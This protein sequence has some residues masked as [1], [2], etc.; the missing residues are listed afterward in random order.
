MWPF[1]V[2][3]RE[4][5]EEP[6]GTAALLARARERGFA[7]S[8]VDLAA[9]RAARLAERDRRQAQREQ[10]QIGR[11]LERRGV[12]PVTPEEPTPAGWQRV[13]GKVIAFDTIFNT[14][15]AN[16][17][18]NIMQRRPSIAAFGPLALPWLM[19]RE[20]KYGNPLERAKESWRGQLPAIGEQVMIEEFGVPEGLWSALGGVVFDTATAPTT[21]LTLGKGGVA[22]AAGRAAVGG[23][24]KGAIST[25]RLADAGYDV[26]R[27]GRYAADDAAAKT[28]LE[29]GEITAREMSP[30]FAKDVAQAVSREGGKAAVG[31]AREVGIPLLR[32]GADGGIGIG[33]IRPGVEKMSDDAVA[34]FRH[35]GEQGVDQTLLTRLRARTGLSPTIKTWG[36]VGDNVMIPLG[37]RGVD[38]GGIKF[39]GRTILDIQPQMDVAGQA[40][41]D[42]L[43]KTKAGQTVE[44]AFNPTAVIAQMGNPII[45]QYTKMQMRHFLAGKNIGAREAFVTGR[46]LSGLM[47][48][49]E[50]N[51]VFFSVNEMMAPADRAQRQM[52]RTAVNEKEA[53]LVRNMRY[54]GVS[55]EDL[56]AAARGERTEAMAE[57]TGQH[58]GRA[59]LIGE[60]IEELDEI[61]ARTTAEVMGPLI[62]R[63]DELVTRAGALRTEQKS[64]LTT[65]RTRGAAQGPELFVERGA[66]QRLGTVNTE[67]NQVRSDLGKVMEQINKSDAHPRVRGLLQNRLLA[68]E[69]FAVAVKEGESFDKAVDRLLTQR[70]ELERLYGDLAEIN[71]RVS[72]DN[73][74]AG[75]VARGVAPER[76]T[77][78]VEAVTAHNT[79][80]D[81]LEAWA[82]T[83]GVQ[84]AELYEGQGA[85][86]YAYQMEQIRPSLGQAMLGRL[87]DV[88]VRA[89]QAIGREPVRGLFAD[90]RLAAQRRVIDEEG[91]R[92]GEFYHGQA[93]DEA[94]AA[95]LA[96]AA[97]AADDM[98][99]REQARRLA[100]DG[101]EPTL[102]DDAAVLADDTPLVEDVPLAPEPIQALPRPE[103][104]TFKRP[105]G[106]ET[107]DPWDDVEE[108]TARRKQDLSLAKRHGFLVDDKRSKW[109]RGMAEDERNINLEQLARQAPT[110]IP[111]VIDDL[112]TILRG[113]G[114]K[115]QHRGINA[116][117]WG[118]TR[119]ID[120]LEPFRAIG[121][122]TFTD[123][124]KG[125][126]VEEA[127]RRLTERFPGKY[128][129][130]TEIGGLDR[131]G[132]MLQ[133]A[134]ALKAARLSKRE[135]ARLVREVNAAD[136]T[137]DIW[138]RTFND[139]QGVFDDALD[140]INQ[141]MRIGDTDEVRHWTTI[142]DDMDDWLKAN[143]RNIEAYH[144]A[145]GN[146]SPFQWLDDIEEAADV[147]AVQARRFPSTAAV[148]DEAVPTPVAE[149]IRPDATDFA[150]EVADDG[151][152][153]AIPLQQVPEGPTP[154]WQYDDL[155]RPS[156]RHVDEGGFRTASRPR[157]AKERVFP[158]AWDRLRAGV[159]TETDYRFA[160]AQKVQEIFDN[161]AKAD[162]EKNIL[163]AFG[164]KAAS[165][166][167]V[168]PGEKI[169]VV[170]RVDETGR[171]VIKE[172]WAIPE[173]AHGW[174]DGLSRAFANDES[175]NA[176][177]RNY[178]RFLNFW[179][180]QATIW[181][182]RFH[183]RNVASNYY[184]AWAEG[185]GSPKGWR[186]A[187]ELLAYQHAKRAGLPWNGPTEMLIAGQRMSYDEILEQSWKTGAQK[188]FHGP[189]EQV[190]QQVGRDIDTAR[191]I[192]RFGPTHVGTMAGTFVEDGSRLSVF[193][194]AMDKGLEPVAA[195][196]MVDRALFN[197]AAAGQTA[198]ERDAMKRAFPFY[199]WTR[200]VIPK[201]LRI[202]ATDPKRVMWFPRTMANF[203]AAADVDPALV[204]DYAREMGFLPLPGIGTESGFM[205]DA[206][207]RVQLFNPSPITI[208]DLELIAPDFSQGVLTGGQGMIRNILQRATPIASLPYE[209]A[210]SKQLFGDRTLTAQRRAP[211]P[212]QALEERFAGNET[213]EGIKTDLGMSTS[214]NPDTGEEFVVADARALHILNTAS[215]WLST[216][217]SVADT[218]E[219]GARGRAAFMGVRAISYE[220]EIA[221]Q[222]QEEELL[223]AL[224]QQLREVREAEVMERR[225]Q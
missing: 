196:N 155:V 181:N 153:G 219:R 125:I 218:G 9:D 184:M 127:V 37:T 100:D 179:K 178:D 203:Q 154:A 138:L 107:L 180:R 128:D 106:Y 92:A 103:V 50:A 5:E 32:R 90:R 57:L 167:D 150:D 222:R 165:I 131:L 86:G 67:L 163:P 211:G 160:S 1:R 137:E 101:Y 168:L 121:I 42:A 24:G 175:A 44:R 3:Q 198:F 149:P 207:G 49:E 156:D 142:A 190:G 215:P 217:M 27:I 188:G 109:M 136:Y 79:R 66:K 95:N 144:R 75:L 46:T 61:I 13:L 29:G 4:E 204:P 63:R 197:Y 74:H 26:A 25:A 23:L 11:Q 28:L 85:K 54:R 64:L 16:E 83:R 213:W 62:V 6:Q 69:R 134:D 97:R 84:S 30:A 68:D 199:T 52:V 47:T 140:R 91:V 76:A 17:I 87:D 51:K 115:P 145:K 161:V 34:A 124:N 81:D 169:Y 72:Y 20:G 151:L 15:A 123:P 94:Q 146:P 119:A 53:A 18:H 99:A 212:V 164:R 216:I 174:I 133:A 41:K 10:R 147:A 171:N 110:D 162:L 80:L 55:E 157:V 221:R 102:I 14:I 214:V 77:E 170:R 116:A 19:T 129:D 173:Q 205:E 166:D 118:G 177:W 120:E 70:V 31:T 192:S 189:S 191:G 183:V 194:N 22:T 143:R 96:A 36:T 71:S 135:Y 193:I 112:R 59:P 139:P 56:V 208:Q 65:L 38:K 172:P 117:S 89:Q 88:S 201:M 126:S 223:R 176:F 12:E 210:L 111:D 158:S 39:M 35:L 200:N 104:P 105:P 98:G 148:A 186:A 141:A 206:E 82:A 159:S 202:I 224:R 58:Y 78:L 45:D 113:V 182:L 43:R 225:G 195:A 2:T 152:E 8:N 122:R 185:M 187:P 60:A 130:L 33:S 73:L 108:V 114:D 209:L 21:G 132:E 7:D 48:D 40:I 93:V 220:E